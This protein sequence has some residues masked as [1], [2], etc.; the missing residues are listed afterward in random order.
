VI[1]TKHIIRP[2]IALFTVGLLAV[3]L[4]PLATRPSQAAPTAATPTIVLKGLAEGQTV[5]G[6]L[7]IEAVVSGSQI[8]KVAFQ[9]QGSKSKSYT[10][11][12]APYFFLGD[13]NGVP[14][15]WDTTQYPNG[16]YTLTTIAY[17]SAGERGSLKVGFSI[18]NGAQ[19]QPTATQPPP[20]ATPLPPTATPLPPTSTPAPGGETPVSG[21][22]C[23][24]WVHDRNVT[25]GP[26]GKQY[27]TWHPP[28]DAQ[29]GCYFGHEH[30]DDPRTSVM[31]NEVGMPPFGYVNAIE[32]QRKEDHVGNKVYVVND[33]T[34]GGSLL[35][36]MHQ[37]THSPDAFTN[38]MHELQYHYRN[39]DGRRLDIMILAAFGKSGEIRSGCG[40]NGGQT[41]QTGAPT[42]SF[43]SGVRSIPSADC[44]ALPNIPYEDWLSGNHITTAD[45]R[46]LA[47]FDPHFA[48]FNPSRFYQPGQLNNLGRSVDRC[49]E[50]TGT[51]SA[52]C[53]TVKSNSSITWDSTASPFKGE[54]RE[55]YV[56]QNW[57]T[58]TSGPNVWYCDPYGRAASAQPFP[59][60]VPQYI[61]TSNYRQQVPSLVF[62]ANKNYNA[63]GVHSPN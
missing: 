29:Y 35:V 1:S 2:F 41:I 28:I 12:S 37:G 3:L 31:F 50:L 20:T 57:V 23:P 49:R 8:S 19:P 10:D 43:G 32:G 13:D 30:G 39:R 62:G 61:S 9:L 54:K 59:G 5:A 51:L 15:G 40:A 27:P 56:N 53:Q 45:G 38:N 21:Q 36:K 42:N 55:M 22:P 47:Y 11:R 6:K 4:I 63:A 44:F 26:D 25:T 48:V 33:D 52:Q 14:K 58:N 17:T 60:S 7:A 18:L 34:R 24:A 16:A 46:E